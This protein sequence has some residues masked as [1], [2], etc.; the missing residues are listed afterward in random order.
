[1]WQRFHYSL[2][3]DKKQQTVPDVGQ[4][5]ADGE[6]EIKLYC[7]ALMVSPDGIFDLNVD[8]QTEHTRSAAVSLL[9]LC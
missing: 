2:F 3:R 8:L 9:I 1:M 4:I 5:E 7:G 6:L